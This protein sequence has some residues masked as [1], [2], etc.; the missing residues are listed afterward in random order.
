MKSRGRPL[1]LRVNAGLEG[2]GRAL[3]VPTG[4]IVRPGA[5]PIATKPMVQRSHGETG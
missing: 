3:V 1:D 4:V 2:A 5:K